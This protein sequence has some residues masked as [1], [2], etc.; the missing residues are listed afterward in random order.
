MT[1]IDNLLTKKSLFWGTL[2]LI[3]PLLIILAYLYFLYI[4][5]YKLPGKMM[6]GKKD[7]KKIE[8]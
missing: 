1:L 2:R 8:I 3:I 7:K 6:N 5:F 4:L